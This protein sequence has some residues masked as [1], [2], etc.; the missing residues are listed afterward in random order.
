M[1]ILRFRI[2]WEEDES[3]YRDVAIKHTQTFA[4]L[5]AAIL[6]SYEFDNK[7]SATFHRSNDL[8]QKGREISLE[9]YDKEYVVAPLMMGEV[10][11]GTEI[12]DPNQKFFYHYD[13][14]K[15]WHFMVELIQVDKELDKNLTYPTCIRTEGMA[16]SQY[17]AKGLVDKRL[18]E[19]EE[20]YDLQKAQMDEGYGSEGDADEE[21]TDTADEE[22]SEEGTEDGQEY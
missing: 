17:G 16:P 3:V 15:N 19:M 18:A 11:L 14:N 12:K 22:G 9:K 21:L 13:F 5:H 10:I 2:Y 20:K 8:W 6:A 4:D 7:H 1:A